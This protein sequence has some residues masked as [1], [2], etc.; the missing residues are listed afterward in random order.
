MDVTLL[1][2]TLEEM[3]PIVRALPSR[4]LVVADTEDSVF[5]LTAVV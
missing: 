4:E 1:K 5:V 2:S 3:R